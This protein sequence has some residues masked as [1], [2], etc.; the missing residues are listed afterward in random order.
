MAAASA[1]GAALSLAALYYL[2]F[3]L[4]VR[5]SSGAFVGFTTLLCAALLLQVGRESAHTRE[6]WRRSLVWAGATALAAASFVLAD[7]DAHS[8]S[9]AL[10]TFL[11]VLG[12]LVS[13]AWRVTSGALLR[14]VVHIPLWQERWQTAEWTDLFSARWEPAVDYSD[15]SYEELFTAVYV[16]VDEWYQREGQRLVRERPGVKPGFTDVFGKIKQDRL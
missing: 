2:G 12:L 4:V 14:R 10:I 15:V 9:D 11:L 16:I 13:V 6:R 7:R 3:F 1:L 8:A 5:P